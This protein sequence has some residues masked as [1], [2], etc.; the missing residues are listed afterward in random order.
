MKQNLNF[1]QFVLF[2]NENLINDFRKRKQTNVKLKKE[3]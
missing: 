3:I 1:E 2:L